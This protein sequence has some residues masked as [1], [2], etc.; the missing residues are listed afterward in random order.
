VIDG[1]SRPAGRRFRRGRPWY[2]GARGRPPQARSIRVSPKGWACAAGLPQRPN[3][4]ASLSDIAGLIGEEL[5]DVLDGKELF[6]RLEM[7]ASP[8]GFLGFPLALPSLVQL[9]LRVLNGVVNNFIC[10]SAAQPRMRPARAFLFICC[11]AAKPGFYRHHSDGHRCCASSLCHCRPGL[12]LSH[13]AIESYDTGAMSA[14]GL[15]RRR[16]S[17]IAFWRDTLSS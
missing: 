6:S 14:I 12:W 15:D 16:A 9:L 5:S 7:I 2:R 17:A 4:I 10:K 1:Q 8:F 13:R 11:W 3:P